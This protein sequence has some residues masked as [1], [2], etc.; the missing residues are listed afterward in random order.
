[1]FPSVSLEK[2]VGEYE[3]GGEEAINREALS[4]KSPY[5]LKGEECTFFQKR[6]RWAETGKEESSAND[7]CF[8]W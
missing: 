3:I 4:L 1:M 7:K 8:F 6:V 2:K 5:F